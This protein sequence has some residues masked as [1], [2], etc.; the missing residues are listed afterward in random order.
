MIR[1]KQKDNSDNRNARMKYMEIP[2][3]P[4]LPQAPDAGD[5]TG[6]LTPRTSIL[7][8][9]NPTVTVYFPPRPNGTS[10]V[11]CPGGGYGAI[12][13]TWE[14]HNIA[15]WLANWGITP[16]V[17]KYRL[18]EGRITEPPLPLLDA[19]QALR[20][21]R[22]NATA[23][24][25]NPDRIGIMGFSAGGHLA[26]TTALH[27]GG[28]GPIGQPCAGIE[29]RP[30]FQILL[31]PV[32]TFLPPYAHKGS[33]ENLIGTHASEEDMR[34]Y[35]GELHVSPNTPPA[36]LVHADDDSAVPVQNSLLLLEA[37]HRAGVDAELL[38]HPTGG[39]GFSLGFS[40]DIVQAPDWMPRLNRWMQD[41][42][43]L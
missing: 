28:P 36:F 17:L 19:W 24:Q 35:S 10:V 16:L 31:Y 23:W 12:S 3:F 1:L 27:P 37:L 2:L 38:R 7:A 13:I 33:R 43:W 34:R 4:T 18:P 39:H 11:I 32:V 9:G 14:G 42:G 22:S 15:R 8:V 30:H 21:A 5:E 6:G 25:L 26:M 40:T 41:R 20:V 29:A